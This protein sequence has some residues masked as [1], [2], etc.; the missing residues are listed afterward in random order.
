MKKTLLALATIASLQLSTTA[1]AA[2]RYTFDP[3]HTNITWSA[4]HFGFSN[5]SGKFNDVE[6]FIILDEKNPAKSSVDVT[7]KIASLQTGI[8]KFNNHLKTDDF[9][10]VEKF[11]TARFVSEKIELLGK[12]K[13]K[14]RGQLTLHGATKP[15][16]LNAK[17]N[18]IGIISFTQVKTAGF[19]ADATIKRS[20][21]GINFGIPGVSDE[22]KIHIEAEGFFDKVVAANNFSIPAIIKNFSLIS[23]ASAAEPTAAAWKII[24]QNS[25]LEFKTTQDKSTVSGEFSKFEGKINFDPKQLAGSKI[26]I[27]IDT[28]SINS[29][30]K[31]AIEALKTAEWLAST[32][33]PKATFVSNK[34]VKIDDKKFRAEGNL[35]IKGKTVP[36]NLNFI[37]TEFSA[38]KA[39][40]TGSTIIKRSDFGIGN[41]DVGKANG[42][43]EEVEIQFTINAIK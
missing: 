10:D 35:T 19:S 40:A 34:F 14:I 2:D 20:E 28:A 11:T 30:F 33:N 16:T 22:V 39:V 27:T 32:T 23:S 8:E 3:N 26:A 17:L 31:E 5:P 7:I 9:F 12:N 4:N 6:G 21:F 24:P 29:S 1:N 13:A 25:K 41:K 18:K 36:T 15:I 38:N 37:L 43:K 42:V